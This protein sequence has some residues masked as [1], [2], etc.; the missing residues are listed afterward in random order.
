[1]ST[2]LTPASTTSTVYMAEEMGTKPKTGTRARRGTSDSL[3]RKRELD[4]IAQR[5][6]RERSKNRILYLEEKLK[7][8]EARDRDGQ[9]SSL[10]STIE[11][12]RRQ[13]TQLKALLLKMRSLADT[14]NDLDSTCESKGECSIP[15]HELLMASPV[16]IPQCRAER[17]ESTS[18]R[19]PSDRGSI[20][21]TTAVFQ[22]D[23]E[24]T[25]VI[26][27]RHDSASDIQDSASIESVHQPTQSMVLANCSPNQLNSVFHNANLAEHLPE[28]DI[29]ML[30]QLAT[31]DA[32]VASWNQPTFDW[33]FTNPSCKLSVAPP[34]EKWVISDTAFLHALSLTKAVTR[35]DVTLDPDV[36]VKAILW[37]WHTVEASQRNHP[38]WVALRQVDE[39]V[40]GN[41][42]RKAQKVAMMYVCQLLM[43]VSRSISAAS[44]AHVLTNCTVPSIPQPREPRTRTL[45]PPTSSVTRKD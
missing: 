11:D 9:I 17:N 32:T 16:P 13:N 29:D 44:V 24:S 22:D 31:F 27:E 41:W 19:S 20:S 3:S 42:T 15:D 23:H 28:Y 26:V 34:E 39:R 40:F 14:V 21:A 10:M 1:M 6:S 45:I 38:V 37:G 35:V 33:D 7:S 36:P 12:L 2:K 43:Q 30:T 18:S 25:E 4:R 8:L 5:M